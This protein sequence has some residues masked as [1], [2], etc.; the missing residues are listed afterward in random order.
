MMAEITEDALTWVREMRKNKI[1]V[2]ERKR[3]RKPMVRM[4]FLFLANMFATH[5]QKLC[6]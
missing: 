2:E 4:H 5:D 3:R 1:D 6:R